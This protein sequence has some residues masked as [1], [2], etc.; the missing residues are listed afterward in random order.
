MAPLEQIAAEILARNPLEVRSLMQGY[1]RRGTPLQSEHAPTSHDPQICA[2]T[3]AIAELIA[4]RTG[5]QA[6][7]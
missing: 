3:A 6:P 5:Q 7:A 4:A 2:V 1:L